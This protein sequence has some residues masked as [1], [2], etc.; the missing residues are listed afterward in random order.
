MK[1]LFVKITG[2]ISVLIFLF[3]YWGSTAFG[4][5]PVPILY[6]SAVLFLVIILIHLGISFLRVKSLDRIDKIIFGINLLIT[7][8]ILLWLLIANPLYF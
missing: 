1:N 5:E 3:L 2:S 8:I 4:R 6:L 7:I